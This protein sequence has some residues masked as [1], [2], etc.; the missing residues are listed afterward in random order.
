MNVP[1]ITQARGHHR[2]VAVSFA[3]LGALAIALPTSALAQDEDGPDLPFPTTLGGVPLEVETF[4]GPEWVAEFSAAGSDDV[5]FIEGTDA[6][7]EGVGKTLDDL[8]V[9]SALVEPSP[10]NVA[11]V[12]AIDVDGSDAR[13]FAADAIDLLLGDVVSPELVLRP[14]A[15]KWVLRVVDATMPGVYPRTVYLDGNT[16]WIIQGD[17]PLVWE[18][19]DQL[20]NVTSAGGADEAQMVSQLPLVLDGRRRTGLYEATEPLFMPTLSE[21]L[22]PPLEAWLLDL[23]LGAGMTPAEMI[24][25]ITWWGVESSQDSVQIE[26]YRL[27][28]SDG[29]LAASLLNNVILAEGSDL[30]E[31][32]V[33]SEEQIAGRD[34]VVLDSGVFKQY[35]FR[36]GDTVWVVTDNADEAEM[37]AEAIAALP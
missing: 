20:P 27:P 26:G 30:P 24:G 12:V 8:T 3:L 29:E 34:V 5:T 32:V 22:G 13:E 23:Y 28:G 15:G 14:V 7:L 18:A 21:R 11:V 2:R 9:K 19:L 25:L 37:T 6:L 10:G 17:E 33:R 35:L 4:S 16:A 31:G 36:S 1:T